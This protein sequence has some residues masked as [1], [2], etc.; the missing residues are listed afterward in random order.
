M[1]GAKRDGKGVYRVFQPSMHE[2]VLARLELRGDLQRALST[3]E[4]DLH[5]QPIVRLSDGRVTGFEALLRWHHPERGLVPPDQFV[6]FAEESGLIVPIGRWVLRE[7]CRRAVALQRVAPAGEPL[8]ISINLSVKQLQHSDVVAD[9]RDALEESGLEPSRLTLEIT[10]TVVMADTEL[11]VVRLNEL[12]ELGVRLAMDDFGTGYSSLSSLS[13]F[14]VDVI[15]MDRSFLRP[16]ASPGDANLASA[17]LAIGENLGLQ[18]V[19]EGIE[20]GSQ[21]RTLRDLGCHLGQGFLFAAPMDVHR[22]SG[23]LRALDV[24]PRPKLRVVA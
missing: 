4:L 2:G 19:A 17:V 23:F 14:P 24:K 7:G 5:Y 20:R 18:V 15:K 21:W 8:G 3:D 6:P 12:K 13:R 10:E 22:A 16:D 1:Y 9:V 11:A